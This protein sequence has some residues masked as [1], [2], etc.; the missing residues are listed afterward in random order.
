MNRRTNF[1][2]MRRLGLFLAALGVLV[3]F[4][5]PRSPVD[6]WA[7]ESDGVGA[8][9]SQVLLLPAGLPGPDPGPVLLSQGSPEVPDGLTV[10]SPRDT[11]VSL[12]SLSVPPP[13]ASPTGSARRAAVAW[14]ASVLNRIRLEAH[15]P[16]TLL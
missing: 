9:P 15:A 1:L 12:I 5:G 7:A 3:G 6:S 11:P 10:L 8:D 2:F 13:D 14:K 16:P 4:G